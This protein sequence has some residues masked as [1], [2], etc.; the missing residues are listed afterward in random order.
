MQ[1]SNPSDINK[2]RQELVEAS[3]SQT[4]IESER[5][6]IK[7]IKKN[8]VDKFQIPSKLAGKLIKVY[9][10]QNMKEISEEQSE[11]EDLFDQINKNKPTN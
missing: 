7:D 2:I 5:D 4:R 3:N 8:L 1:I 11:L 9:H 6:L 10:E